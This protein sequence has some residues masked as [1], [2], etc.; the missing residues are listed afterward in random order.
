MMRLNLPSKYTNLDYTIWQSSRQFFLNLPSRYLNIEYEFEAQP[1]NHY[2]DRL[3]V[4][5]VDMGFLFA[6]LVLSGYPLN[7]KTYLLN[8]EELEDDFKTKLQNIDF[9]TI[10]DNELYITHCFT[11]NMDKAIEAV[12]ESGLFVALEAEQ[13]AICDK[14]VEQYIARYNEAHNI[15]PVTGIQMKVYK[16]KV[17]HMLLVVQNFYD[18]RQFND[19]YTLAGIIPKVFDDINALLPEGSKAFYNDLIR[20]SALK[21]V[22]NKKSEDL[23]VAAMENDTF[24]VDVDALIAE[25]ELRNIVGARIRNA[26]RRINQAQA[27][28]RNALR[29]YNAALNN[30]NT[31]ALALKAIESNQ[32]TF[33]EAYK[34]TKQLKPILDIKFE[35]N[36][37]RMLIKTPLAEYDPEIV[38]CMLHNIANLKVRKFF[39][40]TF[41]N[42]KYKLYVIAC[43]NFMLTDN[44]EF[45]PPGRMDF[46][47]FK[48]YN[49]FPNPHYEYFSCIGG[50]A[51]ELTKA[52]TNGD[53]FSFANIAI[54]ATGSVNFADGPVARGLISDLE[55]CV[56]NP[57]F[58]Q[59]SYRNNADLLDAMAFEDEEGNFH[60]FR[61]LF[62]EG[63]IQAQQAAPTLD[64]QD[65]LATDAPDYD[66]HIDVDNYEDANYEDDDYEDDDED[67]EEDDND[68]ET[69]D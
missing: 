51:T 6:P 63:T 68:E 3:Y 27:D 4:S 57:D 40:D 33:I 10:K 24:A 43:F 67:Y 61:E 28:A 59:R 12:T 54:Q 16:S 65:I 44:P 9:E 58:D 22:L 11:S 50:Y 30:M 53:L 5:S 17:K 47:K 64:V 13:Q 21:H 1:E 36:Y 34:L 35:N 52:L 55:R 37:L 66:D 38:R 25:Q 19:L 45:V 2:F 60:S 62:M 23:F 14:F 42:Q 31:A 39:E 56:E 29:D 48:T 8:S 41:V 18:G 15:S 20:R 32:D 26:E 7:T 49:A 46:T 69:V